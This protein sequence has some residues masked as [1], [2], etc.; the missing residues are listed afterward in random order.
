M[1]K[2]PLIELGVCGQ[3]VWLDYISRDLISSGEL[4]K[5]IDQ[6]GLSGMTSNPTI[7]EKS[8]SGSADYDA[9]LDD[10]LAKNPQAAGDILFEKISTEDI[11]NA[12]DLLAPVYQSTNKADGFVSLEVSPG[13]SQDTKA[14]IAQAR[15]LWKAV[16]RPNVMIKIPAT[17]AGIPAIETLIA[18]GINI[19]ITLMFTMAHYE[20]VAQ[21]YIHGLQHCQDPCNISS[22]ASFFVSRMDTVVDKALEEIGTQEALDLRGTAAIANSKMI[23]RRFLQIFLGESFTALKKKGAR[24]QRPLWASTST[25]NPNYLDVMYIEGLVGQHTVNTMPPDTLKAFRDHGRVV[26]DA[27]EKGNPEE[28]LARLSALNINLNEVGEKLQQD[29]VKS[30]SSS[31]EKLISALEEKS[32]LI[33]SN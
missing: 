24:L 6:D 20:A 32:K 2:N 30:F 33:R 9:Q 4:K 13:V 5:L 16:G 27:V 15:H 8:I 25:K 28:I 26:K 17:R 7:F 10:L 29:G 11:Q 12:A 3:G 21:A 31:F 18:E 19:N 14:T 1:N 22:V 23:Y